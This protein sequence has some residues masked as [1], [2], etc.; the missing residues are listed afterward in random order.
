MVK[1][2][3]LT[4][5][6]RE[7]KQLESSQLEEIVCSLYKSSNEAKGILSARFMGREYQLVALDEYKNK[8]Y[9]MFFPERLVKVPS[10]KDGKALI[11]EFRKIGDTEMVLDLALYYVECCM[12]FTTM[13][14]DINEAFYNSLCNTFGH[15]VDQINRE[16]SEAIYNKFKGRI[17][18][19]IVES[20][21][22]GWVAKYTLNKQRVTSRG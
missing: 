17:N 18:E 15:F 21:R 19:L 7:L 1:P 4:D 3:K 20:S 16:G 9:N 22:I 6:K 12:D 11:T 13:Y 8:M 10:M 5:L 2:M 14:G